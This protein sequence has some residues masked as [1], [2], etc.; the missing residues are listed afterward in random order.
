MYDYG[1]VYKLGQTTIWNTNDPAHLSWGMRDVLI[2]VSQDGLAWTSVG[3][4][5]FEQASGLSTYEGFQGPDLDGVEARYLL[6]TALSNWGGEC[7]GLS[8]IRIEAEE[9]EIS[10]VKDISQNAC[11]SISVSPNPFAT[12]T[13]VTIR[14]ICP[15][16]FMYQVSDVL[17]R[18][19]R[20]GERDGESGTFMLNMNLGELPQGTY[21]LRVTQ[22]EKIAQLTLVKFNRR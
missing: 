20:H 8:E 17:G 6:V 10:S 5:A 12:D 14:S 4:F 7:Y 1:E 2:E 18:T 3:T 21:Y 9:T 22:E 15:R 13:E 16:K 11:F 19:V